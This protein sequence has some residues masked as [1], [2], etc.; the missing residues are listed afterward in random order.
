MA[1]RH[2]R[3]TTTGY[4]WQ[5]GDTVEG[6]IGLNL[7]DGTLHFKKANG[8]YVTITQD[9]G[10]TDLVQDTTPQLG[11]NLDVNGN[12]IVSASNGNIAIEPNGTGIV[13]ANKN[14]ETTG[15]VKAKE[16][17]ATNSSGDEGG[18]INLAQ[19]V[20]NSTLGG[21]TVTVD[22]WQNRFRIFEQGGDA[23]GVY[24]DLTAAAAGVGTNLLSGGGGITDIVQDTTP[25]LG[26][27]LDVN[28]KTITSASNSDIAITPNGT[29]SVIID[30]NE[31]PQTQ[32]EQGEV[33]T[34]DGS[35]L[36]EWKLPQTISAQ[37]YNADSVT[38]NK[39]EP[40]YVFGSSGTNISVKRALNTGDSTSAQTLGLA[41]E[42][43]TA[44]STGIVICQGLLKNVNTSSYT[45]GQ[46]LYLGASAGSITTT[47]PKEPNHLVYLGFV[48]AVNSVSGRIYV[49]AQNGY[50]LDEIHDVNINNA[51][52]LSD[53]HY[54]RYNSAN[55]RW[56]NGALDISH[57]TTPLLGGNLDVGGFSIVSSSNANITIEPNGTGDLFLNTDLVRIGDAN[58]PVT[59]TSNGTGNLV[60]NTNSGTNSGTITIN[61]GINGNIVLAPNGTG[62]VQIDADTLRVGDA[63][64]AATL[65]SNGTGNLTI[66][67]NSGTNSGVITINQGINGNINLTPNG[68]GKVV[69]GADGLQTNAISGATGT[70]TLTSDPLYVISN[71]TDGIISSS[72]TRSLQLLTNNGTNSGVIKINQGANANIQITPNGSGK[73]VL[74]GLS[75]PNVDG[76]NNQVLT[77]N[78]TGTLS[79]ATP[80]SSTQMAV[81]SAATSF[82]TG[83]KYVNWDTEEYDGNNLVTVGSDGTFTI[84]SAG[85][86]L[87][88]W[89]TGHLSGDSNTWQLYNQTGSAIL[90]SFTNALQSTSNICII[91][92]WS[93]VHTITSSNVYRWQSPNAGTIAFL[94]RPICHIIK[95]S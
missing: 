6:Q 67:T 9:T 47:K 14:I 61:Q 24:I 86:Y 51:V 72:G 32:G 45:A 73:I 30:G 25:Q 79:W 87:I 31:F 90:K 27:D 40:V 77:T 44:G 80:S 70:L 71:S 12:K 81:I 63:N 84:S 19:A 38:I 20:T 56:E 7:T 50:E 94:K 18:Q 93:Y 46:A 33:L 22:I 58:S 69:I 57:D 65:T 39:G 15:D 35:G 23:R 95:L 3:T 26:G 60:L 49:R 41:A 66:S 2:K 8:T 48:E 76:T 59:L 82:F 5:S 75:W 89:I 74:D 55:T 88:H 52:A 62:D 10:I 4:T 85:T 91:G 13:T 37:V 34:A 16:L 1:I 28:G 43:I 54:L 21:D 42:N 17:W 29:G 36:V 68:T 92:E 78:G 53:N 64:A 83:T 11:G